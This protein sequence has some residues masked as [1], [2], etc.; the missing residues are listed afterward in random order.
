VRSKHFFCV[1]DTS[2]KFLH[3]GSLFS[4]VGI[5][6]R[7]SHLHIPEPEVA[8]LFRS[9]SKKSKKTSS[10]SSS[11]SPSSADIDIDAIEKRLKRA[12]REKPKSVEIYNQIAN[13]WRIKGDTQATAP[14]S[15]NPH[16]GTFEAVLWIRIRI[17]IGSGFNRVPGSAPDP[18]SQSG[19]GSRRG[20][21]AHKHRKS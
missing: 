11:S 14:F 12:K 13:Y 19:S 18:D 9:S 20:K 8:S 17:R 4:T 3:A 21:M 7:A 15:I 6:N 1:F 2:L 10:S 5:Q 16:T